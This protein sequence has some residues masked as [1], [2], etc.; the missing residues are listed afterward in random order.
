MANSM[1]VN[2]SISHYSWINIM[3][4]KNKIRG[5]FKCYVTQMGWGWGGGV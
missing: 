4:K 5:P 2:E 1:G 3:R